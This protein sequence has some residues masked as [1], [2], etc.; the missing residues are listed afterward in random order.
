MASTVSHKTT[1]FFKPLDVQFHRLQS[2]K[3]KYFPNIPVPLSGGIW[4]S[5]NEQTKND[6][7]S[8]HCH[9]VI[10]HNIAKHS[11]IYFFHIF[12]FLPAVL[13]SFGSDGWL[14]P[15]LLEA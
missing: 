12:F 9:H 15:S 3:L 4:D 7:N 11:M 2:L 13:Y 6:K 8:S 10:F 14:W 5:K 1:K